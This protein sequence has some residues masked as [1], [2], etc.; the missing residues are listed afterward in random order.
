MLLSPS[1]ASAII[2]R[3]LP[4]L[5][6]EDCGLSAAHGRTLRRSITTDRDMPAYDRVTM[7]GFAINSADLASDPTRPFRIAGFQAA[8]MRAQT[9]AAS[10][11]AI[12]IRSRAARWRRCRDSLRRNRARR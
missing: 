9:I 3:H 12:E 1:E 5:P 7:D 11:T 6:T 4:T 10:H 8:G 2:A